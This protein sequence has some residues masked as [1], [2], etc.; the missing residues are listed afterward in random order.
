VDY[1]TL[2]DENMSPDDRR[3]FNR[4][5]ELLLASMRSNQRLSFFFI[6]IINGFLLFRG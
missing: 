2:Y 1:L 4:L 6:N 3:R 5:K